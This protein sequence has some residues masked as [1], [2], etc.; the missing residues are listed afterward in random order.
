MTQNVAR[1]AHSAVGWQEVVTV[2]KKPALS[3]K[4]RTIRFLVL[5]EAAGL[6]VY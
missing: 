6:K 4:P 3:Q 2:D 5:D 1:H